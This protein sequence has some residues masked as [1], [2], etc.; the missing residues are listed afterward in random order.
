M[1]YYTDETDLC[2]PKSEIIISEGLF[3]LKSNKSITFPFQSMAI[4]F[5]LLHNIELLMLMHCTE[6]QIANANCQ[7]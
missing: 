3:R 4:A 2:Y 7:R 1:V 5:Q 6:I